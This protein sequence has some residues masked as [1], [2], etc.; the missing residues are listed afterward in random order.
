MDN[1]SLLE[2][3]NR[4]AALPVLEERLQKLHDRILEAK[5]DV[6]ALLGRYEKESLDVERIKKESFSSS[7]LKMLGM[8]EGRV[9]KETREMLDAKTRYDAAAVRLRELECEAARLKARIA[10]LERDKRAYEK[11][12]MR[13]EALIKSSMSGE[14]SRTYIKLCEEAE[15]LSRQLTETEEALMAANRAYDTAC[16]A[17]EYLDKA[18]GWATYDL[19][20]SKGL[21]THMA[22]YDKIDMAQEAFGRLNAQLNELRLELDDI[23]LDIVFPMISFDSATR[24]FEFWFD[25]IF[26][27]LSVRN[28]IREYQD[29]ARELRDR[30]AAVTDRLETARKD[31]A[32]AVR[33]IGEQQE[34][35]IISYEPGG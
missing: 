25:N 7:L 22:K 17:L 32:E 15:F 16:E 30:I 4:L 24:F 33:T 31:L 14:A 11:E 19:W 2:L 12:Y 26:T 28:R 20:F 23:D 21:I 13:R 34:E 9:E 6:E 29:Y 35:I 10:G 3:K 8:Y 27:D 18:E 1:K 5:A